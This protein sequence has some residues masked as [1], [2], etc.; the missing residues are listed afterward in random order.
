MFS[1]MIKLSDLDFIKLPDEYY[2][3]KLDFED[4]DFFWISEFYYTNSVIDYLRA[5]KKIIQHSTLRLSDLSDTNL[6]RKIVA[7]ECIRLIN[8]H[9][10]LLKAEDKDLNN[11]GVLKYTNSVLFDLIPQVIRADKIKIRELIEEELIVDEK[12]KSLTVKISNEPS[13]HFYSET[14]S[15]FYIILNIFYHCQWFKPALQDIKMRL[16]PTELERVINEI[17]PNA[18]KSFLQNKYPRT[19]N[20]EILR[21][22]KIKTLLESKLNPLNIIIDLS[23]EIDQAKLTDESYTLLKEVLLKPLRIYT[24]SWDLSE[25]LDITSDDLDINIVFSFLIQKINSLIGQPNPSSL[26]S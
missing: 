26:Q 24:T 20:A 22:R 8:L 7:D 9:N 19:D 17:S 3:Y 5:T 25:I 21:Y 11:Y 18:L 2:D 13:K 4:L 10:E 6:K 12:N 16:L 23:I 1:L 15:Y 14:K